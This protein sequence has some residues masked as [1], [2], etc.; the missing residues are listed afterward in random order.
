MEYCKGFSEFP[1]VLFLHLAIDVAHYWSQTTSKNLLFIG[2]NSPKNIFSHKIQPSA[3]PNPQPPANPTPSF[4]IPKALTQSQPCTAQR[5]TDLRQN[6]AATAAHQRIHSSGLEILIGLTCCM[7]LCLCERSLA[8]SAVF[9]KWCDLLC[10]HVMPSDPPM[11]FDLPNSQKGPDMFSD[12]PNWSKQWFRCS[13][14]G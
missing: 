12:A 11:R 9:T 6:P 1:L 7:L 4:N 8:V 14:F 3:N 10:S 5:H 13:I 2:Q